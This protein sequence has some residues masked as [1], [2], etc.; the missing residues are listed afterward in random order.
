VQVKLTGD[1]VTNIV[2]DELKRA[3]DYLIDDWA[4][5]H[6][7][8]EGFVFSKDRNEDLKIISEHIAALRLVL[9]FYGET[10]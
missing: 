6:N 8:L 1:Q 7:S 5:V 4:K 2:T 9:E 10:V 3:R